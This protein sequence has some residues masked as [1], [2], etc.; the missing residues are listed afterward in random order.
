MKQQLRFY[1]ALLLSLGFDLKKLLHSF[2]G[3]PYYFNDFRVLK[4]QRKNSSKQF[5]FGKPNLCLDDR[6]AESGNVKG[7]YFYQDWLVASRIFQNNPEIHVDVG[8]RVDGFVA[9]VASFR[10]IRV[11]D[12]RPLTT[13]IPQIDFV[14]ADLMQPLKDELIDCC[15]SLSCLHTLEH[16]GLGRYGDPE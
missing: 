9:H 13:H 11:I 3:L 15:D 8:S 4:R 10:S 12:I 1:N 14:S 16:F 2:R 7:H 6:F 5:V